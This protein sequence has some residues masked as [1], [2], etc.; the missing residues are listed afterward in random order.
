[1]TDAFW[2]SFWDNFPSILIAAGTTYTAWR[3]V[4]TERVAKGAKA[5][6]VD[7]AFKSDGNFKRLEERFDAEHRGRVEDL[8]EG[9]DKVVDALKDSVPASTVTTTPARVEVQVTAVPPVPRPARAGDLP[10]AQDPE[11]PKH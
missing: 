2:K 8:K 10:K 6:A 4:R 9:R 7:A 11:P 1:M 5:A 3:T